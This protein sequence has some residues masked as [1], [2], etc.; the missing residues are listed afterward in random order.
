MTPRLVALVKRVTELRQSDLWACHHAEEFNLRWIRP[1]GPWE[2]MVYEDPRLAGPSHDP[3]NSKILTSFIVAAEV[4]I[5]SSYVVLTDGDVYQLVSRMFDK[6]L[7]TVSLDSMLA[8][9]Y[10]DNPPPSVET[11]IFFDL[12]FFY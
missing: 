1:L 2:K 6:S 11:F 3:T 8:P 7:M 12:L 10:S 9:Y 5:S 4:I